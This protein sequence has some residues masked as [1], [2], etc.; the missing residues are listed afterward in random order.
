MEILIALLFAVG[1]TLPN[2]LLL[3]LGRWLRR[4]GKVDE[5]FCQKASQVVFQ[6]S[7]P[8][9]LLSNIIGKPVHFAAQGRLVLA[10]LL[11]TFL[12]YA[13]AE[14]FAH[15]HIPQPADKGVFVQGVFRSNLGIIG[16]AFVQNAYG[17]DGLA[18]SA[19]YMGIVT[20]ELNILAVL[21][22]SRTKQASW[23]QKLADTAR[24]IATNPLIAAIV[25]AMCLNELP[26][27]VPEPLLQTARYL[28]HLALPL[29]LLCAGATFHWQTAKKWSDVS[30]LSSIGRLVVAPLMAVLVGKCFGLQGMDMGILFLMT[31]TPVAAASYVMAKAMGGN[32]VAAANI[33]GITTVGAMLSA[34]LG[35]TVLRLLGWM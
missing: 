17:G 33:M 29:A 3:G 23:R 15:F 31:A 4:T 27:A 28:G 35:M 13:L 14:V 19:V 21:T 34:G 12:L 6:W 1:V 7:L 2:I 26:W 5:A 24:K 8:M 18:N 16:L 25:L 20:I 32:D 22:L 10:G 30:V 9:L 11:T